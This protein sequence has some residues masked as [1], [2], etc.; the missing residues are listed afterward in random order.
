MDKILTA[1]AKIR[2]GFGRT[3]EQGL[4]HWA[5][6]DFIRLSV[7]ALAAGTEK[8]PAGESLRGL[9]FK[10]IY[11]LAFRVFHTIIGTHINILIATKSRTTFT[12]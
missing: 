1:N 10:K 9:L 3:A 2:D 11:L 8:K 12:I 5:Q 7:L 4:C 6:K